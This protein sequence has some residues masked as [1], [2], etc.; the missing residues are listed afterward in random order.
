MVRIPDSHFDQLNH[1]PKRLD[2]SKLGAQPRPVRALL[3][4]GMVVVLIA[5]AGLGGRWRYLNRES[6][7]AILVEVEADPL[8]QP[9]QRA[10]MA[11]GPVSPTAP[12]PL[13][14]MDDVQPIRA[15]PVSG[16]AK[17][18]AAQETEASAQRGVDTLTR[19]MVT[20]TKRIKELQS[21]LDDADKRHWPKPGGRF[22][23]EGYLLDLYRLA[24]AKNDGSAAFK[25]EGQLMTYRDSRAKTEA[26]LRHEREVL[27]SLE[28]RRA[29]AVAEQ[30]AAAARLQSP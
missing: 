9:V 3:L 23:Y 30:A 17:R 25:I 20:P 27:A 16:D 12:E 11:M 5:L 7:A 13:D 28:K 1:G 18:R 6:D 2:P 24:K 4:G 10:P 8:D 29:A 14:V 15:A 21:Q 19:Q 26:N 22:T